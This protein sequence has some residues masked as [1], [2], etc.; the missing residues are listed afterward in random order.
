VK[1]IVGL[2]LVFVLSINIFPVY[3]LTYTKY[4]I[5]DKINVQVNDSTTLEF[6]VIEDSDSSNDSVKA[7][8]VDTLENKYNFTNA[9]NSINSLKNNWTNVD[10]VSLP[11]IEDIFK[12]KDVFEEGFKYTENL[13]LSNLRYWT[14]D[15][16][17]VDNEKTL[18]KFILSD[19]DVISGTNI[20]FSTASTA[21][22]YYT[23][24]NT[25]GN[26]YTYYFRGDVK[27]NY[28][29][30]GQELKDTSACMYNG[31][32]VKY[33]LTIDNNSINDDTKIKNEIS[34]DW[35]YYVKEYEDFYIGC[36]PP[37][38]SDDTD[39]YSCGEGEE[40]IGA[41]EKTEWVESETYFDIY[42][43][44]VRINEDGS[45]RLAHF[46]SSLDNEVYS[47][48]DYK[49]DGS[50]LGPGVGISNG[51]YLG[52]MYKDNVESDIKVT[53]DNWYKNNMLNYSNYLADSGFC[54][55]RSVFKEERIVNETE[56]NKEVIYTYYGAYNRINNL[57]KPQF[58][59]PDATNDLFTIKDSAKGN[60]LLTYPI[61]LLTA[62]ELVYAGLNSGSASYLS[63]EY[64]FWTM[65]PNTFQVGVQWD[66]TFNH[67][68]MYTGNGNLVDY[69]YIEYEASIVPVINLKPNVIVSVNGT[70]ENGTSTN[71]YVIEKLGEISKVWTLGG[72]DEGVA[73]LT[74]IEEENY[75]KPL[76]TIS[77]QHI[78]GGIV[79][80]GDDEISNP[81]TADNILA[82]L[83]S[84]LIIGSAVV[85]SHQ[86]RK[87]LQNEK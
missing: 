1:K 11:K 69:K 7:I 83:V 75:V 84:S 37:A 22:L 67:A 72:V 40:W 6:Y 65:S 13:A 45:I 31:K 24:K 78:D 36:E 15:S 5:G 48:V 82:Y 54:N 51:M 80:S 74:S 19:N 85:Y 57:K 58:A 68:S 18:G 73:E 9:K 70:G 2:L 8:Y 39:G 44:I 60:K 38:E 50:E 4:E 79:T 77:K 42:W 34:C 3:A 14:S 27:N 59:C 49:G 16:Y 64:S 87:L 33:H 20:D 53:L 26:E 21:G 76:I 35:V 52:Y 17:G 62:D 56:G 10:S 47:S 30:F 86:K 29:K 55:D 25:E 28:V 61:G 63:S 12:D 41:W 81:S 23:N 43:R 46:P 71:P 66:N 32:E